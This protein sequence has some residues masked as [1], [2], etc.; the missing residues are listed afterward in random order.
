MLPTQFKVLL[1][2]VDCTFK[3]GIDSPAQLSIHNFTAY[4]SRLMFQF[5]S[6]TSITFQLRSAVIY[7]VLTVLLLG[8]LRPSLLS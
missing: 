6:E 8:K 2:R 3:A 4:M 7:I 1:L 5:L